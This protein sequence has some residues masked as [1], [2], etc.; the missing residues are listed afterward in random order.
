MDEIITINNISVTFGKYDAVKSVSFSIMDG[1]FINIIGPNGGGKSTLIK[2]LIGLHPLSKGS[3]IVDPYF[4]NKIGYLPQKGY[5]NDPSFPATVEEVL[6]TGIIQGK[7]SARF[8]KKED[9][10]LIDVMLKKMDV[11][12]LKKQM[13]SS[14]SG[15]QQQRIFI[16]R[17]LISKPRILILDEPTSALD[18]D[19]RIAFYEILRKLNKEEKMTII[20]VTHDLDDRF[21]K[22]SQILHIDQV[23]KF[24]GPYEEFRHNGRGDHSHV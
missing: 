14:L 16:I 13:I 5:N 24:F 21:K 11:Y 10:T 8:I 4:Q 22:G 15:G 6:Y 9:K 7:K 19:F 1:D 23:L 18:A 17:A 2:A 3:I 12:H 20:N